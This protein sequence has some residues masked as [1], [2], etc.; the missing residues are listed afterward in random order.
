MEEGVR[1]AADVVFALEAAADD[2]LHLLDEPGDQLAELRDV[3][4]RFVQDVEGQGDRWVRGEKK[5]MY[6]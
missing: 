3:R 1:D 2:H 4:G 5:D 6:R